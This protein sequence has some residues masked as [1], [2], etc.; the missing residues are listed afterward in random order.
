MPDDILD[1]LA[2][3]RRKLDAARQV[4]EPH[5]ELDA[6]RARLDRMAEEL[7]RIEALVAEKTAELVLKAD[8]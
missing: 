2:E 6:M 8:E 4:L 3:A 7:E 5:P 1:D